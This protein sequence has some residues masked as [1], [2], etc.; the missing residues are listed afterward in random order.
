MRHKHLVLKKHINNLNVFIPIT[1]CINE[2]TIPKHDAHNETAPGKIKTTKKTK[3]KRDDGDCQVLL[4]CLRP[5]LAV[6][7]QFIILEYC[8]RQS[9][10]ICILPGE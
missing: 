4:S 6:A 2:Q 10:F 9:P 7:W 3:N 1:S 5:L 8:S